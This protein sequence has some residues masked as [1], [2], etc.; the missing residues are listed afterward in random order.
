MRNKFTILFI[1]ISMTQFAQSKFEN[2]KVEI[3]F[4]KNI[5]SKKV[6][7]NLSQGTWKIDL[8]PIFQN[9]ELVQNAF[10]NEAGIYTL[11]INYSDSL[12]YNEIVLYKM[13]PDLEKLSF[14]FYQD[15]GRVFCRIKSEYAQELNKEVVLNKFNNDLQEIMNSIKEK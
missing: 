12:F 13:K 7:I 4:D 14:D 9:S 8:Y 1:L 3:S 10:P 15:S 11:T 5:D 6:S 2:E